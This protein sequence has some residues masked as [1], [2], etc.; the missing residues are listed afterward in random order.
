MNRLR[1]HWSTLDPATMQRLQAAQLRRFL[2]EQVVPFAKYYRELFVR[3]RL[4]ADDFRSLDDLRRLPFTTKAELLERPLDFVIVPDPAILRRRWR[5]VLRGRQTL[6]REYR[7]I[8]LT[9]TTGRSAE[10]LPFVYSDYDL[11]NLTAA[12]HRLV[13]VLGAAPDWRLVNMFPY[14]PHLAFWQTDY[15]VKAFGVFT[16]STGGGKVMGTDGNLRVIAKTKPQGLIGMPTFLYHLLHQAADEGRRF[17]SLQALVLGGEKVPVGLRRKLRAL[18]AQLGAPAVKIV[19]TYG[20]TEAKTA[21]GECPYPAEQASG[22]YHLYPDLGLFEVIDPASGEVRGPGEPGELVYTPLDAR[23]SVVLRYRTGDVIE[24][25]LVYEPC[26]HCGRRAPRLVGNISRRSEIRELRLDKVKGT[27]VDFNELEHVLDGCEQVGAWQLELRK[28]NDDPLELDELILHVQKIDGV[29]ESDLAGQLD[30]RIHEAAEM[31]P[32]RIEF[33][34][35]AEM[36]VLQGVGRE[37]KEQRLVD[38]RQ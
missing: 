19:G 31:R 27:L 23:G 11:Q 12:G 4:S 28:R 14:A 17:E 1:Q 38:H 36:R 18:A 15:A 29:R 8:F 26:P 20:F 9:S 22:G 5:A 24:G 7:P 32:N 34:S 6:T 33:H 2:R 25:G 16:V 13:A 37:L 3:E 30:R 35:L 21:W 10:P